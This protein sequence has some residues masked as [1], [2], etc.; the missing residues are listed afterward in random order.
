VPDDL[1]I[2]AETLKHWQTDAGLTGIRDPSE[3]AKLPGAEQ[4]D[5]RALWQR[6]DELRARAS[7]PPGG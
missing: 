5:F 4:T 6:V 1:P 7:G 3:L 2:V